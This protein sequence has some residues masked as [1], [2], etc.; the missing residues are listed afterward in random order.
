MVGWYAEEPRYR[1]TTPM[2]AA[3][4]PSRTAFHRRKELIQSAATTMDA[5]VQFTVSTSL[6]YT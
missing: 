6:W 5:L 4:A 3:T 2:S 1:S